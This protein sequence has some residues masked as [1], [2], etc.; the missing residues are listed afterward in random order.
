LL[1]GVAAVGVPAAILLAGDGPDVGW[2][3]DGALGALPVLLGCALI[4]LGLGLWVWTLMLLARVGKGTL[5]PWDKTRRL[6]VQGPYRHVRNPM[7][8]A[9]L[10]VLAGQAA[11]FGSPALFVWLGIFFAANC[12]IFLAYEEPSLE[13]RFGEEY[14]EYKQHV[15]RWIPRRTPWVPSRPSASTC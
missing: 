11:L 2:G 7:I 5:A 4:A 15:P 10:M 14:R 13:R 1:P 6:V 9:M 12:A 3:L 8:T